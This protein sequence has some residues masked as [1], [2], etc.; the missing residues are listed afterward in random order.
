MGKTPSG[1]VHRGGG[2]MGETP[3]RA[4]HRG[5][6]S[7]AQGRIEQCTRGQGALTNSDITTQPDIQE[8]YRGLNSSHKT[9]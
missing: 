4:V 5:G 3:P 7:S 1:A 6:G 8:G 9:V 2:S